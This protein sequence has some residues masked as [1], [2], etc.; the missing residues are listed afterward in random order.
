LRWLASAG[1][2]SPAKVAV[3]LTAETKGAPH[4]RAR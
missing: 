1:H 4:Y 2:L 3:L